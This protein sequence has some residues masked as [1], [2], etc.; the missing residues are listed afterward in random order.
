MI[1]ERLLKSGVEEV[2]PV[3]VDLDRSDVDVV[4]RSDG[5]RFFVAFVGR[6]G[7]RCGGLES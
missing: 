2:R 3:D 1:G 6:L 5:G 7:R 4:D